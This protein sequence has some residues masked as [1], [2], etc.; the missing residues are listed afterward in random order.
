MVIMVEVTVIRL[1]EELHSQTEV[2]VD[3]SP[4]VMVEITMGAS[5]VAVLVP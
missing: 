5:A 2:M 1:E 3:I 4:V